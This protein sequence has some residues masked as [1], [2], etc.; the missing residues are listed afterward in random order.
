[1]T[2]QSGAVVC[3]LLYLL[4]Y[5]IRCSEIQLGREFKS[6]PSRGA[7]GGLPPVSSSSLSRAGGGERPR[8]DVGSDL[9]T[10]D[11]FEE[12][13]GSSLTLLSEHD[14]RASVVTEITPPGVNSRE[15]P[16]VR[17]HPFSFKATDAHRRSSHDDGESRGVSSSPSE[18]SIK[19]SVKS[20]LEFASSGKTSCPSPS[21]SLGTRTAPSTE[22]ATPT[23]AAMTTP[24]SSSTTP[25]PHTPL[26]RS[27]PEVT[28]DSGKRSSSTTITNY[29]HEHRSLVEGEGTLNARC[30]GNPHLSRPCRGHD[31]AMPLAEALDRVKRIFPARTR[32][33]E[34]FSQESHHSDICSNMGPHAATQQFMD[35]VEALGPGCSDGGAPTND[36]THLPTPPPPPPAAPPHHSTGNTEAVQAMFSNSVDSGYDPSGPPL[37]RCSTL[38]SHLSS[39]HAQD[40]SLL[41][42]RGE[43]EEEVGGDVGVGQHLDPCLSLMLTSPRNGRC[44]LPIGSGI[45]ARSG[46]LAQKGGMACLEGDSPMTAGIAMITTRYEPCSGAEGV[47]ISDH[48]PKQQQQQQPLPPAPSFESPPCPR[49]CVSLPVDRPAGDHIPKLDFDSLP[50]TN[51]SAAVGATHER[52]HILHS[53]RQSNCSLSSSLDLDVEGSLPPLAGL[54]RW[55]RGNSLLGSKLEQHDRSVE[56]GD[57][58]RMNQFSDFVPV[59]LPSMQDFDLEEEGPLFD[60]GH[61]LLVG[62]SA[63]YLPDF[64]LHGT[65]QAYGSFKEDLIGDLTNVIKHSIIDE[66]IEHGLAVVAS[67]DTWTSQLVCVSKVGPA[68]ADVSVTIPSHYIQQLLK[69][70]K[71][72][73]EMRMPSEFCLSHLEDGLLVLNEKGKL[74]ADTLSERGSPDLGDELLASIQESLSIQSSDLSL[75]LSLAAVHCHDTALASTIRHKSLQ[76][77]LHGGRKISR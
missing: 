76:I 3:R 77:T 65:S 19:S 54:A 17:P 44:H 59:V 52:M 21:L 35:R 58:P 10:S 57:V 69:S 49:V 29:S 71:G 63:S 20:S 7:A 23:S 25:T 73:W 37:S 61:S 6:D 68:M 14:S 64:V 27:Q 11:V 43:G 39:Y 50:V 66:P 32:V 31:D 36:G 40:D 13:R 34:D 47:V 24:T 48:T 4:S 51:G 75:L 12:S 46:Y 62:H 33:E 2:G 22:I 42:E 28:G 45:F 30:H 1:M 5:F 9:D 16:L 15:V 38:S 67:T 53:K 55:H 70:V 26:H 18:L 41:E 8:W 72:M 56:V 74:L 60:F